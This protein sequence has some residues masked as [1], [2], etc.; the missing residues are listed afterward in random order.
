MNNTRTKGKRA[1][2]WRLVYWLVEPMLDLLDARKARQH[3]AVHHYAR[4]ATD[5][6]T[7]NRR[8]DTTTDSRP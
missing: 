8:C 5:A 6:N 2:F 1:A 7:V 4:R 3:E